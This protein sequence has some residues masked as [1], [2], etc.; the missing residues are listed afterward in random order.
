MP[1]AVRKHFHVHKGIGLVSDVH[2]AP[3]LTALEGQIAIGHNRYSTAGGLTLENTQPLLAVYGR[4]KLEPAP[5]APITN[6]RATTSSHAQTDQTTPPNH[7]H[8]APVS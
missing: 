2:R 6:H 7:H 1:G 8:G 4:G 5:N 3:K